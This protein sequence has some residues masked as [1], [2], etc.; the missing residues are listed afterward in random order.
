MARHHRVR[1][2]KWLLKQPWMQSA[3]I[4]T[5]A[6]YIMLTYR[7]SRWQ[8]Q[9]HPN[10]Q[11]LL[12]ANAPLIYAFWHGRLLMM[13]YT[14]RYKRPMHVLISEHRDG[15]FI[16]RVCRCFKIGTIHG[17]S[18][19]GALTGVRETLRALQKGDAVTFTPDGPRGP[20][21]KVA[22]GVVAVAAKAGVPIIPWSFATSRGRTLSSWDRFLLAFPF[23]RGIYV[24][25]APYIVGD[26]LEQAALDLEQRLNA[27]NAT[28]DRAVSRGKEA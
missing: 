15:L 24:A 1:P 14:W 16:S 19:K 17:S 2:V 7:T 8:W 23:S 9:V 20:C 5:A 18:S 3:L 10:A 28:A 13:P 21:H 4:A 12:D 27:A 22:P 11:K 26:D 6:F 25:G